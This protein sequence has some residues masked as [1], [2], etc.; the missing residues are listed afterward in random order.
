MVLSVA[1]IKVV[2]SGAEKYEQKL[3]TSER[4]C[5]LGKNKLKIVKTDNSQ[6]GMLQRDS[7]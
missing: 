7:E 1:L 4:F 5:S 3:A 2:S 6:E